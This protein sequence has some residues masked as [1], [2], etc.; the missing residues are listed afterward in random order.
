MSTW[1]A[2]GLALLHAFKYYQ[3][4]PMLGAAP[5]RVSAGRGQE[6]SPRGISW[7]CHTLGHTQPDDKLTAAASTMTHWPTDGAGTT[8]DK[9]FITDKALQG[10][11]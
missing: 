1:P 8:L 6:L 9:T 4:A 2:G 7:G 11:Y 3:C 10:V 5:C